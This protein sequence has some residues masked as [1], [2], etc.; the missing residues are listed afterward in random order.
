MIKSFEQKLV[1]IINWGRLP[2]LF[3]S[4]LFWMDL[5]KNFCI[6]IALL[7]SKCLQLQNQEM[8]FLAR[9]FLEETSQRMH[10]G[11]RFAARKLV[12][13]QNF[14]NDSHPGLTGLARV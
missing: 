5:K 13:M 8:H 10:S 4:D 6:R 14:C 9:K 2:Q 7:E 3:F 11:N 12:L 1:G